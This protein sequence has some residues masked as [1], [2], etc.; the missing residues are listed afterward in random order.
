MA[1]RMQ[2]RMLLRVA[3]A[4]RTVSTRAL[5]VI[6]GGIPIELIV[7]ERRYIHHSDTGNLPATR[8][9]QD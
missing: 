5:Q 1:E 7:E 4:Y 2:R 6:A 8:K 9:L 3:C